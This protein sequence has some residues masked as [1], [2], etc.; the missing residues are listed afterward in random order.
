MRVLLIARTLAFGG[1]AEKLVYETYLLLKQRLGNSNVM[2]LVFEPSS[3]F[4]MNNV[5]Y[6]EKLLVNDSNFIVCNEVSVQLSLFKKNKIQTKQ[7]ETIVNSFKPTIIH[8]HLFRAELYS[9]A[10][11]YRSAK[12]FT[13]FHD[14]MPQFKRL[15]IKS[16]VNKARITNYFERFYLVRRYNSN[17]GT[18]ILSVSKNTYDFA[19]KNIT[20]YPIYLLENAIDLSKFRV[21]NNRTLDFINIVNVGS[22][23][24]KKNQLF[25][26]EI[27][28]EL[29]KYTQNFKIKLLGDGPLKEQINTAISLNGLENYIEVIGLV[30]NVEDYLHEANIYIHTATY[31]PMG[32]VLVEAMASGLPII[33]LDGKGNTSMVI[34]GDNGYMIY[35]QQASLFVQSLLKIIESPATYK[36]FVDSSL[37]KSKQYDITNYIDKLLQIY[38]S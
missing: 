2:L 13:H 25:F 16:F 22:F 23:M 10:I 7:L 27:A 38:T 19:K 20:K 24:K 17:G 36:K 31:E 34:D 14:N 37:E 1:G 33:S 26:I 4:A 8:S 28:K 32:L 12:W 6:Y 35:D 21:N 5:D 3:M 18:T 9:R 29:L 15:G 11:A 30:S